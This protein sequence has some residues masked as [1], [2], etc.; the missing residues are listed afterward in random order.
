M[1]TTQSCCRIIQASSVGSIAYSRLRGEGTVH[2][3]FESAINIL[4]EGGLVS[5]VPEAVQRGPLNVTLQL[6]HGILGLSFLEVKAGDTVNV[7]DLTLELGDH[8]LLSFGS[9]QI[10]S[11]KQRFTMPVLPNHEIEAN[12]EVMIETAR[13]LGK[14]SG[15]GE[16]FALMTPGTV[17]AMPKKLN[18]FSSFAIPRIIRLENA[19]RSENKNALEDAIRGLI[20]LGPGLTP[21]S[22]DMLAGLVLLCLLYAKN[23]QNARRASQLIAQAT[24]KEVRGRTTL[25]SEELLKQAVSGRGNEIVMRLCTTLLT[26]NPES[27]TRETKH[28]LQ[29]GETS[30]TDTVLGIALGTLLA[31][32]TQSILAK[33]NSE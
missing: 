15:L 4:F 20:G 14:M 21:S 30:G 26:G 3:V 9:A 24:S 27:V 31:T 18:I 28:V 17:E 22:D 2:G 10:Y 25:L 33:R 23:R 13:V 29:I 5:L 32:G 1:L 7:R 8:S 12:L 16:L 19:F 11:P 6:P